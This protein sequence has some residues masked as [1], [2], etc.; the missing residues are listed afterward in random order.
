MFVLRH[1]A[2]TGLELRILQS[3]LPELWDYRYVSQH[4]GGPSLPVLS[5]CDTNA[6][7]LVLVLYDFMSESARQNHA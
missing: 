6:L 4:L 1:V 5:D 3:L 2:Q 7:C